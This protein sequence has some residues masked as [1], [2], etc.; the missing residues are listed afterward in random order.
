M[1]YEFIIPV[2]KSADVEIFIRKMYCVEC[3]E[4]SGC[5]S[6]HKMP[7]I[8]EGYHFDIVTCECSKCSATFDLKFFNPNSIINRT[9]KDIT[10]EYSYTN[11]S[12][13]KSDKSTSSY[14]YIN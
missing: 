4:S 7:I 11:S 1:V 6:K 12:K 14:S 5:F 3:K 8:E 13:R 2:E 10:E 9:L